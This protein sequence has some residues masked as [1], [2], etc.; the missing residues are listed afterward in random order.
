MKRFGWRFFSG[1]RKLLR[2]ATL[3]C[4]TVLL[5]CYATAAP[6]VAT[7]DWAA[8]ETLAAIGHPPVSLG[9]KR[10]YQDWVKHPSMP[11]STQDA[12]LRFQPN[13][14]HL[15]RVQPDFFVQS[16][17]FTFLK[18]Q[19][20]RI[21][22]VHEI[23]FA[24]KQGVDY[25]TSVAATRSLGLLLRDEAAAE[26]LVRDTDAVFV[27]AARAL[28]PYRKR[29]VA[30]VQFIDARHLRVYGKT[31]LFQAVLDKVGLQNAWSGPS[32]EWGFQNITLT[33]LAKLPPHT[34]LIIV[35]PHPRNVRAA[36]EKSAL[37]QRLPFVQP[38]N[39]RVLPPSWSY[40]ALPSMQR[41]ALLL[42]QKL[43]EQKEMSW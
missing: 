5:C 10:A 16:P 41:F 35:Q 2:S 29:P 13:L 3:F 14:E 25:S 22:P 15:Y 20:E 37:W 6:R 42:A 33:D 19:F 21:A 23:A 31:S 36:L 9:D 4:G 11:A 17:W 34:L 28:A 39:R 1:C 27:Q 30:V 40:G 12:G 8:A 26:K 43:P 24:G 32:N 18:P 7:S 38:E